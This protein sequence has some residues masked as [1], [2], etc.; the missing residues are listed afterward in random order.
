MPARNELYKIL[1]HSVIKNGLLDNHQA[2]VAQSSNGALF[3][4]LG[5]QIFQIDVQEIRSIARHDKAQ[6]EAEL[7][8]A[9]QPFR[10][11]AADVPA[12]AELNEPEA[13]PTWTIGRL[14][15]RFKTHVTSG[16]QAQRGTP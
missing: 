15:T 4:R 8:M 11:T 2:E 7:F 16:A 10:Y 14:W 9:A 5:V 1:A 6:E 3:I 12:Y 13:H